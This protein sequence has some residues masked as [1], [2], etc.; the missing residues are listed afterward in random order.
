MGLFRRWCRMDREIPRPT[1]LQYQ[2][3]EQEKEP[4]HPFADQ[5]NL[6]FFFVADEDL[7]PKQFPCEETSTVPNESEIRRFF[8]YNKI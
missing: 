5:L 2:E 4:T 7:T 6:V 8:F 3:K 1:G